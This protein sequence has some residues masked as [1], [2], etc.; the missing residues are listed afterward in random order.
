MGEASTRR[1]E[2]LNN[3]ST[4]WW[5]D[6]VGLPTA[7]QFRIDE[8]LASGAFKDLDEQQLLTIMRCACGIFSIAKQIKKQRVMP[9]GSF[10]ESG[11]ADTIMIATCLKMLRSKRVLP[12]AW[13][14][15]SEIVLEDMPELPQILG[16]NMHDYYGLVCY[17]NLDPLAE[18]RKARG[19]EVGYSPSNWEVSLDDF[20]DITVPTMANAHIVLAIREQLEMG[21]VNLTAP[22]FTIDMDEHLLTRV[23]KSGKF[24][25]TIH[26]IKLSSLSLSPTTECD[27]SA[28]IESHWQGV[29]VPADQTKHDVEVAMRCLRNQPDT[30]AIRVV[31]PVMR[32][33]MNC[34]DMTD[35]LYPPAAPYD[36]LAQQQCVERAYEKWEKKGCDPRKSGSMLQEMTTDKWHQICFEHIYKASY[37]GA[38]LPGSD[39]DYVLVGMLELEW[40]QIG[41]GYTGHTIWLHRPWVESG[42][43]PGTDYSQWCK[44]GTVDDLH[45]FPS[46]LETVPPPTS[47][48][49]GEP[50]D[51]TKPRKHAV[52]FYRN[53]ETWVREEG[54]LS[55]INAEL[56]KGR[57][58]FPTV[59]HSTDFMKTMR[60][61][62]FCRSEV[63]HVATRTMRAIDAGTNLGTIASMLEFCN[64]EDK[65]ESLTQ[66]LRQE[67]LTPAM[68]LAFKNK[69]MF[70]SKKPKGR[71]GPPKPA[72]A[73]APKPTKAEGKRAANQSQ[74][75]VEKE[76]AKARA[77]QAASLEAAAEARRAEEAR[78]LA[79]AHAAFQAKKA[80]QDAKAKAEAEAE[81]HAAKEAQKAKEARIAARRA[82]SLEKKMEGKAVRASGPKKTA[83]QLQEEH[84]AAEKKARDDA[85]AK[86]IKMNAEKEAREAAEQEKA[87]A[88]Q[89]ARNKAAEERKAREREAKAARKEAERVA[90]KA[91]AAEAAEL[92]A[93]IKVA[94]VA[95]A[96]EAAAAR[97][98][99]E[100]AEE[101]E[102]DV[103]RIQLTRYLEA[104]RAAEERR[105][106]HKHGPECIICFERGRTHF[107]VVCGHMA[108]CARCADSITICPTCRVETPF[109][110]LYVV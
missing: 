94:Q 58:K 25:R 79:E 72:P 42:L 44:V 10:K 106:G 41:G 110:R 12:E 38:D 99:A 87:R 70:T 43:E 5:G 3:G 31:G 33:T 66:L 85:E 108:L 86:A 91:K 24:H 50:S 9:T 11:L 109:R 15:V 100:R 84:E 56:E 68:W 53:V 39:P 104:T 67:N 47:V 35:E 17:Q 4:P 18:L 13:L 21:N 22:N 101:E 96:D 98:R 7:K 20:K 59:T 60:N 57:D 105:V 73:P 52:L 89:E 54:C 69:M 27:L 107:G 81:E 1:S 34:L 102:A 63:F 65:R 92:A 77:E 28:S 76:L 14:G 64:D 2:H 37:F 62:P 88:A 80:E 75:E 36:S 26:N 51:M 74:R 71:K 30:I 103:R 61:S 55:S 82:A 40:M 46:M 95:E 19:D 29:A 8:F 45:K 32:A 97:A 49:V 93:A 23:A 48:V 78:R 90:A 16:C 83:F 6:N